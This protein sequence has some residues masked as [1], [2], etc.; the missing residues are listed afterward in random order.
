[1]FSWIILKDLRDWRVFTPLRVRTLKDEA[2]RGR[3]VNVLLKGVYTLVGLPT[4]VCY[5]LSLYILKYINYL[6]VYLLK[7]VG[8]LLVVFL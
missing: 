4:K 2:T 1:M 7:G 3:M 6:R 5:Y 8:D